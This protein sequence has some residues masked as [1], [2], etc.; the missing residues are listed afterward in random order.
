[1]GI[2]NIW[3]AKSDNWSLG[4]IMQTTISI[5]SKIGEDGIIDTGGSGSIEVESG[6]D[7]NAVF[8]YKLTKAEYGTGMILKIEFDREYCTIS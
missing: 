5:L 6:G 4:F 7:Y 1:M 2:Q 3:I 8:S